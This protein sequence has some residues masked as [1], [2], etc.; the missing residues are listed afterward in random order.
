MMMQTCCVL[1]ALTLGSVNTTLEY[2]TGAP[3]AANS[4][5]TPPLAQHFRSGTPQIAVKIA[6]CQQALR[7]AVAICQSS[8]EATGALATYHNTQ[9]LNVCLANARTSFDNCKSTAD[10]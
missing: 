3:P 6:E 10:G 9:W 2:Q 7:D 8:F 4:L 5:E 1:L